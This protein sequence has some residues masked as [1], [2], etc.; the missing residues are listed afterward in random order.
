M[1]TKEGR[2]ERERE[3]KGRVEKL[4][5][6]GKFPSHEKEEEARRDGEREWGEEEMKRER[7]GEREREE[8]EGREED[9]PPPASSRDESNVRHEET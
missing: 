9:F 5:R 8:R 3:R 6:D 2:K 1:E 4:T 7:V